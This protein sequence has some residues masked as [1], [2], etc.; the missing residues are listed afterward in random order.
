MNLEAGSLDHRGTDFLPLQICPQMFLF[1]FF[2][3]GAS[4]LSPF[5]FISLRSFG[6][7]C[8]SC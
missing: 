6:V 2:V 4:A 5:L 3:A 8:V 1:I 7:G